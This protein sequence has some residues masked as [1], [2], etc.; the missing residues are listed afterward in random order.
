MPEGKESTEQRSVGWS[1][2][3]SSQHTNTSTEDC[4]WPGKRPGFQHH[5]NM[6]FTTLLRQGGASFLPLFGFPGGDN[7]KKP[8]VHLSWLHLE[9][10][11][12]SQLHLRNHVLVWWICWGLWHISS[13]LCL[14]LGSEC[15]SSLLCL[16]LSEIFRP[17]QKN[18][19]LQ[20][21][22]LE[23]KSHS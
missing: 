16:T 9:A 1:P 4:C 2:L 7:D 18:Y 12:A 21:M 15:S 3:G 5:L 6:A 10:G 23:T 20:G 14:S 13:A 19:D 11:R 8:G 22:K 17:F